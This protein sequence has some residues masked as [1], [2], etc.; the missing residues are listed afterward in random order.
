MSS[1]CQVASSLLEHSTGIGDWFLTSETCEAV[2]SPSSPR[3]PRA[4]EEEE[5][6]RRRLEGSEEAS[7]PGRAAA[8]PSASPRPWAA[9]WTEAGPWPSEGSRGALVTRGG[10]SER[11]QGLAQR[12]QATGGDLGPEE[13]SWAPCARTLGP[14]ERRRRRDPRRRDEMRWRRCALAVLLMCAAAASYFSWMLAFKPASL[15]FVDGS[16]LREMRL[17]H[18]RLQAAEQLSVQRS[19]DLHRILAQV[20]RAVYSK[21][22]TD[23]DS[24]AALSNET[25]RLLK[26]L[27]LH[28]SLHVPS[29]YHYLPHLRSQPH[30]LQPLVHASASRTGVSMV[31]GVPTVKRKVQS[32]LIDTLNSLIHELSPTEKDDC[33][34]VVFIGE[35]N[36]HHVSEI[37]EELKT[38]FAYEINSGLLEVVSPSPSYYPDLGNLR[39]TFGDSLER[40]KWRTKQ[41]L[42]YCYLMMYAQSRGHYYL[43][44]EDD[45]MARPNYFSL[46]K[47][48]AE[49]QSLEDWMILEFS[50]LGFIGKLFKSSDVNMLVEFILMFYRDKPIDWLLDHILWVKVCNPEKDAKHCQRQKGNL[51]LR[52]K[53]SLFQHVGHHS[54]LAGKVQKLTDRDFGKPQLHKSYPNPGGEV[55]T[56]LKVYQHHSLD[57]AYQGLDF[58]WALTPVAGDYMLFRFSQPEK[59][60]RYLFRSG[61]IEHPGDKLHNTT[62]EVLLAQGK[63]TGQEALQDIKDKIPGLQFTDDGYLRIGAFVNGVAEATVGPALGPVRAMRLCM[64]SDSPVW[65]ILSEIQIERRMTGGGV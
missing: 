25:Q 48:F 51:R 54:S 29:I 42:D 16:P 5:G 1:K 45:I 8:S 40:V 52:F 20:Y 35:T 7:S 55:S 38:G 14:G 9:A 47:K 27:T 65:V 50:Q 36:V 41:N 60:S 43:Q 39:E 21:T 19:E 23:N 31:L 11:E 64:L 13:A 46:I 3:L 56:S 57:K 63:E 15:G 2:A 33:I 32:Y 6:R 24:W 30:G 26:E 61:N 49:Q 12:R 37:V 18:E 28:G 58:F 22:S 34:I 59:I 53:P 10:E 62:V 4:T 17:L 44:L